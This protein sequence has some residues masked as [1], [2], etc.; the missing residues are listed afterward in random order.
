M[1]TVRRLRPKISA[2]RDGRA[3]ECTGL[4]NRSTRKGTQGSN[5]CLSAPLKTLAGRCRRACFFAGLVRQELLLVWSE[6]GFSGRPRSSL[7]ASDVPGPQVVISQMGGPIGVHDTSHRHHE[8]CQRIAHCDPT[9]SG[10]CSECFRSFPIL[11]GSRRWNAHAA[12]R[13][14]NRAIPKRKLTAST[15]GFWTVSD[16][17]IDR[18]ED[19]WRRLPRREILS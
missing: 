11:S 2:W 17:H 6:F 10:D 8:Y 14:T 16:R 19:S 7:P 4:E 12:T 5:P 18:A 13:R 1:L 3:A 9:P 15:A